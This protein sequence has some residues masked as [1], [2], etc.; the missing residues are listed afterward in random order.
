MG[1]AGFEGALSAG[2]GRGGCGELGGGSPGPC[3]PTAPR[4]VCAPRLRTPP[5]AAAVR[6][7]G[8]SKVGKASVSCPRGVPG[9]V[10]FPAQPRPDAG[11]DGGRPE[12]WDLRDGAPGPQVP[13][14]SWV[15]S[16]WLWV[17]LFPEPWFSHWQS[18]SKLRSPVELGRN[19][20]KS[21]ALRG[22][23]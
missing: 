19:E 7:A 18:R 5:R 8:R 15:V 1:P 23:V 17:K 11:Q 22:R 10:G 6:P 20:K 9:A 3:P 4:L 21:R 13:L 14:T 12:A 2:S 16:R